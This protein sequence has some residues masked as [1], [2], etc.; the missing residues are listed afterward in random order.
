M[1]AAPL[2][3]GTV[4]LADKNNDTLRICGPAACIQA[5]FR[6]AGGRWRGGGAA[7]SAA[8]KNSPLA[9]WSDTARVF[10]CFCF[11]FLLADRNETPL[12]KT[13]PIEGDELFLP[14]EKG[15][16]LIEFCLHG[17]AGEKKQ[18]CKLGVVGKKKRSEKRR[19]GTRR[20]EVQINEIE[21]FGKKK[22]G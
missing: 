1:G 11:V 9:C 4:C 7:A 13:K 21:A 18:I 14:L 12:C 20:G 10:I 22:K 3:N 5:H 16:G 2:I 19:L 17:F 15:R 8:H 6:R